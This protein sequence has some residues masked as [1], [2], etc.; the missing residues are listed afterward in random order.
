MRQQTSPNPEFSKKPSRSKKALRVVGEGVAIASGAAITLAACAPSPEE[1]AADLETSAVYQKYDK[2][3]FSS[4]EDMRDHPM[5]VEWSQYRY[6]ASFANSV[7]ALAGDRTSNP[8]L[9]AFIEANEEGGVSEG[10]VPL[11]TRPNEAGER[12]YVKFRFVTDHELDVSDIGDDGVIPDNERRTNF[13]YVDN[14]AGINTH[15]DVTSSFKD[16]LNDSELPRVENQVGAQLN[17]QDE[18]AMAWLSMRFN[19]QQYNDRAAVAHGEGVAVEGM[20]AQMITFDGQV[21]TD[22]DGIVRAIEEIAPILDDIYD[23]LKNK[24]VNSL[25]QLP[26][27]E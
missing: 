18:E 9:A 16:G 4:V 10:F 11:T 26:K 3:R 23:A 25:D 1:R 19:Q 8:D 17:M 21:Y 5:G 7:T 15:I 2:P 12:G 27:S 14:Q 13:W 22:K 6:M 24:P 20:H